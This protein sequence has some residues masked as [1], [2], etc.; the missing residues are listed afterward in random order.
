MAEVY[1]YLHP[2]EKKE[3]IC[4][5]PFDILSQNKIDTRTSIVR[6]TQLKPQPIL[7][8]QKYSDVDNFLKQYL[9]KYK[10]TITSHGLMREEGIDKVKFEFQLMELT[11]RLIGLKKVKEPM[12]NI[13]VQLFLISAYSK[14]EHKLIDTLEYELAN[15]GFEK[16]IVPK[17]NLTLIKGMCETNA[18]ENYKRLF[19]LRFKD[20]KEK[21]MPQSY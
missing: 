17:R 16:L 1:G 20:F 19:T 15:N 13:F 2:N 12:T 3:S 6:I 8:T 11:Y 21:I 5:I 10:C 9:K 4:T 7:N 14:L 18:Q